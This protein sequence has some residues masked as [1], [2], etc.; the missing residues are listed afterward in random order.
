MTELDEARQPH[1][2]AAKL[3]EL[4]RSPD[5][6]VREAVARHPR[7]TVGALGTLAPHHA[8]LVCAHPSLATAPHKA[9]RSWSPEAWMAVAAEPSCPPP[10]LG[11]AADRFPSLVIVLLRPDVTD[12][13]RQRA[14]A[15]YRWERGVETRIE[16]ALAKLPAI[17]DLE[18]LIAGGPASQFAALCVPGLTPEQLRRVADSVPSQLGYLVARH[19]A[20]SSDIVASLIRRSGLAAAYLDVPGIPAS[21]LLEAEEG[22]RRDG[23]VLR[24]LLEAGDGVEQWLSNVFAQSPSSFWEGGVHFLNRVFREVGEPAPAGFGRVLER[25]LGHHDVSIRVEV[26]KYRGPLTESALDAL[27]QD[28][29]RVKQSLALRWDLGPERARHLARDPDPVVRSTLAHNH[30]IPWSAVEVL[31]QDQM[32]M[33]RSA[34]R[35]RPDLPRA[36]LLDLTGASTYDLLELLNEPALPSELLEQLVHHDD[37]KV[38]IR[39][40]RHPGLAPADYLPFVF[41]PRWEVRLAIAGASRTPAAVLDQLADDPDDRVRERLADRAELSTHWRDRLSLDAAASVR[42]A[43]AKSRRAPPAQLLRLAEDEHPQVREAAKRRV[44]H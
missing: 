9:F 24:Y 22:T 3:T 41:H 18:R 10:V 27:L 34:C 14:E 6:E 5:P 33:V 19:A 39:A 4:A 26:A 28:V 21:V 8:A 12:A 15:G 43:V 35:R 2:R 11:F 16:A 25:L 23:R 40:A 37:R 29:S 42:L 13:L 1:T 7:T 38:S 31:W 20:V 36:L 44:G 17:G 30:S 32:P